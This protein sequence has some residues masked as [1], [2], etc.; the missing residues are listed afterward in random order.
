MAFIWDYDENQL[1]KSK[2]GRILLLERTANYGP[3]EGEKIKLSEVKKHWK[4]LNLFLLNKRLF[5]L[6]IWGKY[7]SS[8]KSKKLY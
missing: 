8:Q 7:R 1:K 2:Q 6:L 5:E 4:K 3:S